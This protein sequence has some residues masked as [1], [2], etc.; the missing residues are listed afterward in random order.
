M[1]HFTATPAF[2]LCATAALRAC[3]ALSN[4]ASPS[5][6]NNGSKLVHAMANGMARGVNGKPAANGNQGGSWSPCELTSGLFTSSVEGFEGTYRSCSD[7][8]AKQ[9]IRPRNTAGGAGQGGTT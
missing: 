7:R 1:L 8:E 3:V 6:S 4:A 2:D 5:D 9:E